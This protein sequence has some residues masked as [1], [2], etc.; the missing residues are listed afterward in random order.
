DHGE[1]PRGYLGIEL[2][3]V[4]GETAKALGLGDHG[5]ILIKDVQP[6]QAAAKAG[7]R[8]GDVIVSVNKEVLPS[9]QAARH[10]RQ[11]VVDTDPS[12]EISLEV[13]RD[14]QKRMFQVRVGKRPAHLP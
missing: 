3:E 10:F 6:N 9:E 7:L 14:G 12:A 1:V 4:L 5:G 11:L 2:K 8:T 13:L